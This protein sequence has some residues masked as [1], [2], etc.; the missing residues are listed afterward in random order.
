MKNYDIK[1][2]EKGGFTFKISLL[3]LIKRFIKKLKVKYIL[4]GV[5]GVDLANQQVSPNI[6]KQTL[7][8]Y[9]LVIN[10]Q[11]PGIVKDIRKLKSI[12]LKKENKLKMLVMPY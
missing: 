8:N 2:N 3:K 7:F 9:T 10:L 5:G 12:N 6:H 4:I 11:G 1:R